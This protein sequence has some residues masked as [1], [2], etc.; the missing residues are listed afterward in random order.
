MTVSTPRLA[1]SAP[2][3]VC[4]CARAAVSMRMRAA[5]YRAS[6]GSSPHA[7]MPSMTGII[8]SRRTTRWA[9]AQHRVDSFLPIAWPTAEMSARS[10][11]IS[12]RPAMSSSSSTTTT[13]TEAPIGD[14]LPEVRRWSACATSSQIL[15]KSLQAAR[16][17]AREG[18]R[19]ARTIYLDRPFFRVNCFVRLQLP[20]LLGVT[21]L[22]VAMFVAVPE[23]ERSRNCGWA[24]GWWRLPRPVFLLPRQTW[25]HTG[26]I[27]V[28]PVLD[29]VSI[30]LVRT[31]LLP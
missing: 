6:L 31:A 9:F 3:F 7:R 8:Q 15:T 12:N 16:P 5:R 25:M 2:I 4:R 18:E 17:V 22:S 10:S 28:I 27:I 19:N 26:W 1:R 21:L 11:P 13:T 23:L 30:A 20:F 29:I 24:W 14:I